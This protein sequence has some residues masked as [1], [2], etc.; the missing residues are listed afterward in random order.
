MRKRDEYEEALEEYLDRLLDD[1]SD[2][3]RTSINK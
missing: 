1:I 3:Y 2:H